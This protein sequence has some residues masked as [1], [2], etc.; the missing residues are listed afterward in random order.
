MIIL[1]KKKKVSKQWFKFQLKIL[2]GNQTKSI[3]RRNKEIIRK[4]SEI[5]NQKVE[6]KN[7]KAVSL[8]TAING[9]NKLIV[10]KKK[11]HITNIR[12]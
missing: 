4:I 1:G 12:K 11:M 10:K 2:G 5:E 3:A 6:K 8:K 9:Q 7:S